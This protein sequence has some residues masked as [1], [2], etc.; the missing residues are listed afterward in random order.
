MIAKEVAR[1]NLA[2]CCLQEVK[3]RK[4]GKKLINLDTGEKFEFHWCGMKKRREAGVGILIRV[5]QDIVIKDP[6][7]QTPRLMAFDLNLF[8]FRVRLVIVYAPTESGSSESSK[9]DFYRS[10]H[11]ACRKNE[12]HQ[13]LIVAG[14]FNAKTNAALSKCNYYGASI[15]LNDDCNE[16]GGRLKH[17]CRAKNLGIASSFF[18]YPLENRYTWYSCDRVT[19]RVT[20]YVL[21]ERFVQQFVSDCIAE[22]ECDF[23]S[24]HRVLI[25]K[26][27]TPCNR[28]SRWRK[29]T[30]HPRKLD[31]TSLNEI[32]VRAKFKQD[33]LQHLHTINAGSTEQKSQQIVNLLSDAASRTLKTAKPKKCMEIWKDDGQL[34]AL[35][36]E[37]QA[38]TRES[39]EY[40][41]ATKQIK[42]RVKFLRNEKLKNEAN[43]INE[44]ASRREV[45]K[46]YRRMKSS[47]S[48]FK[49][50]N[51][52]SKCDPSILRNHFYQ[53]FNSEVTK[54]EP[55]ELNEVPEFIKTL[56]ELPEN[57]MK[58]SAP[59]MEE[60]KSTIKTLKNGRS[61][62][63]IPTEY[64]K[65]AAENK[66]FLEEMVTLYR[67]IWE[68]HAIPVSWGKSKLVSI[69]KGSSKGRASDP[70]AYRGLQ[71]GSS[72]CKIIIVLILNRMKDWYDKHLLDQQ[73][74]FRSGRGTAD[75]IF[76]TKRV[77]QVA[78]KM[79]KPIYV[80]FVD[81][82]A[83]FD[84]INR[85]WLFKSIKKRFSRNQDIKLITIL[86][87]LYN[88]TTTSLRESPESDFEIT[89]GVRQ[90]GP[91]SPMLFNLF[92]DFV[93][94]IFMDSCK[95]SGIHFLDLHY[96]IPEY[97]S[98]RERT[99]VGSQNLNW[100]GYADDIVLIF[101]RMQNLQNAINLL[102][103]TFQRFSLAINVSKTKSMIVNYQLSDK[104]Y[105]TTIA[106][107]NEE[108]I[109]NVKVFCY[110]GCNIKYNEPG[111][112][113]S[114]LE[115]RIDCA[116]SKFYE[117]SKKFFNHKIAIKTRV[118]I[119]NALV[120]SRLTYSCQAWSLN[121]RQ[122]Q[123]ISSAYT[124]MLRKMVK[125]G[126]KRHEGTWNYVLRN[127]DLLRICK[128]ES[129]ETFIS[130]QQRNYL[131]HLVREDDNRCSKK[132]LFNHDESKKRGP[133]TTLKTIV[134][135]HESCSEKKFCKLAIE[136]KY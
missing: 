107:L 41:T 10:L 103:Q 110:L 117:L 133:R 1:Q 83:A 38:Y 30:R 97:A 27:E 24:D 118:K 52:T 84:H 4:S 108:N 53:H 80:L 120:R 19:K 56:Q 15:I 7:V 79:K 34:N 128:T 124:M 123:R 18:E 28:R 135:R 73:Q 96:R 112:G 113:D 5:D 51:N 88:Y 85:K 111:T 93:M 75:G 39:D 17:F 6:D 67:T 68:T 109:E 47:D 66:E 77:Q 95:Q 57:L 29:K 71:I 100:V 37:R 104:E 101:D 9:D 78:D 40:K 102:D 99:R 134:L 60:L 13:K 69:W 63:D 72:M 105:P 46:L 129:I 43:E 33:I 42:K 2:F 50:I 23:D 20:D 61:A 98:K 54:N 122:L 131:A 12:K 136:R 35:I 31:A 45:E 94:R 115:F 121:Q 62:N 58:T 74:G 44:H 36:N 70:K 90:G 86:E 59:D 25:T 130:S 49:S 48:A 65:A 127:E 119:F 114:E 21:T 91:E 87:K 81:L 64:I 55:I 76:I 92:L 126:F 106:K 8:G 132:L 82:T 16:N 89:L 26:L 11:K 32:P 14:D 125:N 3:Y 116:E 22:P